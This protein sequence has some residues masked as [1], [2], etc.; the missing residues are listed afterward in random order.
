MVKSTQLSHSQPALT[1]LVESACLY[2]FFLVINMPAF[3]I[4]QT[5]VIGNSCID[6]ISPEK[7]YSLDPVFD[8]ELLD[9]AKGLLINKITIYSLD[10]FNESDPDENN[11]LYRGL[12]KLHINTRAYVI[13]SQLLFNVGE[14][15]NIRVAHETERLLRSRSYFVDAIIVPETICGSTVNLAVITRDNW[16]LQPE[17]YASRTGGE[18][19]SG[20]GF[21]E[22][23]LLGTGN[24]AAI[25]YTEEGDETKYAYS[26]TTPHLFSSRWRS[27]IIYAPTNDGVEQRFS[28]SRPFYSLKATWS[29]GVFY[30]RVREVKEIKH[31]NQTLNEYEKDSTIYRGFFG[32]SDGL[33]NNY[34]N[35]WIFS[36]N[37]EI[38]HFDKTKDTVLEIPDDRT[39]T[40]PAIAYVSIED[41]FSTF[42]NLNQIHRTEDISLGKEMRMELG[43]GANYF[44]NDH[45][46]IHLKGSYSDAIGYGKHHLAKFKSEIDGRWI[47]HNDEFENTVI[48]NEVSYNYMSSKK[49]RW[50]GSLRYDIGLGL[51]DDMLLTFE[52]EYLLRGYPSEYQRGNR[53]CLATIER[54]Y[55]SDVHIFNLIRAGAVIFTDIGRVWQTG[56]THETNT[57]ADVGFGFRFSSSKVQMGNILHI[58]IAMPLVD[59][60]KVDSYQ[61]TIKGSSSF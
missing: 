59:R 11:W 30:D 48:L 51:E 5:D 15:L 17:A 20:A 16:S 53:R 34:S 52:D 12:N 55:F 56:A 44:D 22:G 61:F 27:S 39:L 33:Q 18:S 38:K 31:T 9:Q 2:L 14:T 29:A 60:D 13:R 45:A 3:A 37:Q 43:Y 35:R 49:R 28:L 23:N 36:L 1:G 58:D 6:I 32:F 57:L 41:N 10:V 42:K 25:E 4:E 19:R 40:Y 26:L 54:R 46:F 47:S 24:S 8:K 50:F 7:F 21:V